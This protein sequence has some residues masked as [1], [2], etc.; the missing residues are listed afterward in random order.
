RPTLF[1]YTT[2]FRSKFITIR[3]NHNAGTTTFSAGIDK[4]DRGGKIGDIQTTAEVIRQADV[5]QLGNNLGAFT[6]DIGSGTIIAEH[7]LHLAFTLLT[8]AEIDIHDTHITG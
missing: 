6:T 1:P 2:L 4:A 7:N 3:L 5:I 8:T